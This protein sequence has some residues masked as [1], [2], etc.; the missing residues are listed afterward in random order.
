MIYAGYFAG[1][2]GWLLMRWQAKVRFLSELNGD[3]IVGCEKQYNFLFEDFTSKFMAFEDLNIEIKSRNMWLCNQQIYPM[4]EKCF[5]PDR[6]KCI[7]NNNQSFIKYGVKSERK[8]DI[9][10]H[11]RSTKNFNTEYR[12]WNCDKWLDIV[13]HFKGLKV[14]SVGSKSGANY[15]KDTEDLRSIEL[16][17]LAN[18]MASSRVLVSPSSGTAHFA[19]LCG[20][21]HIVWSDRI[22][23]GLYDNKQRY[24]TDWNPFNTKCNFIDS[25]HPDSKTVIKEIEKC[26]L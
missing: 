9:L 21:P 25:W 22:D 13:S 19:S 3:I 24:E 17:S 26:I 7:D 15:I 10:L 12:N 16:K 6:Q 4:A 5:S 1:E 11:D 14:A 8:Y 18:I 23:R 2:F 20:L